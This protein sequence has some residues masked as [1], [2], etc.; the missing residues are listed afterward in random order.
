MAKRDFDKEMESYL[1]ARKKGKP[2]S[3]K[4]FVS[5]L[6][7]KK[8]ETVE[9]PEEVEV[10]LEKEEVKAEPQEKKEPWLKRIFSLKK[11][12]EEQEPEVE[13]KLLA[14]DAVA[15]HIC[16]LDNVSFV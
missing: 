10:Y 5:G 7:P 13:Y 14:E 15:D 9:V 11:E 6:I 8:D 12:K 1:S 3:F 2:F 4:K 16:S